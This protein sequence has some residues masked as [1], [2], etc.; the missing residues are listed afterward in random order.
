MKNLIVFFLFTLAGWQT[1]VQAN[2]NEIRSAYLK[3][4]EDEDATDLLIKSLESKK[5]INSLETAYLG[6]LWGLKAKHAWSP[7]NK[8]KHLKVSK[9]YLNKAVQL[10]SSSIEIRYLRYSVEKNIPDIVG[11]KENLQMDRAFIINGLQK[12]DLYPIEPEIRKT[13]VEFMKL[14]AELSPAEFKLISS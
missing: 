7:S 4:V 9:S 6:A 10:N 3:C 14:N 5:D 1:N 12:K 8:I 2:I 13:I 11:M